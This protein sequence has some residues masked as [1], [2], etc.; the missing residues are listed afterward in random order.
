MYT[1]MYL[2]VV[3]CACICRELTLIDSLRAPRSRS[4]SD[5]QWAAISGCEMCQTFVLP[6]YFDSTVSTHE[7]KTQHKQTSWP[8]IPENGL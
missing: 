5:K 3:S 6:Q 7:F 8:R 2:L 1:H 4:T